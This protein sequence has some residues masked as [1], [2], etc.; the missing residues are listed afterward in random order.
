[1]ST[2]DEIVKAVEG[3]DAVDFLKLRTALDRVEEKLSQELGRLRPSTASR[4]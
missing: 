2:V 1:M 4:N 3:L